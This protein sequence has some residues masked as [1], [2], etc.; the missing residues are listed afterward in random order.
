V[1]GIAFQKYPIFSIIRDYSPKK[2]MIMRKK[3][4]FTIVEQA[5][6]LVPEFEK[7]VRKLEQQVALREQSKSTL[8]NYIRRIALFVTH[9]GKLPEHIDT[10]EINEYLAG[11]ARD[12]KS[13][14]RSSFKHMVYGLRY[15]YRLLGMNKNAIA[16]PSLRKDAKLPVIL[17]HRE[18]KEL[19]AAPALLKQRV[20]LPTELSSYA[21]SSCI[22]YQNAL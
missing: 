17:N 21:G 3:S 7:V 16:L 6:M 20:V 9:F 13:P 14:S 11:L 12:Q 22:Y 4:G 10:E 15:Y 1:G 8:Q 5:I 19:F 18:L 2:F